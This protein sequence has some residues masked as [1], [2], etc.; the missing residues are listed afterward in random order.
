MD[1]SRST[2]RPWCIALAIACAPLIADAQI[3]SG[4]WTGSGTNWTTTA[5]NVTITASAS[6]PMGPFA[7]DILG[8][9]GAYSTSA[10]DLK[11]SLLI[12]YT[13]FT[14]TGT[15]TFTFS[16][17][18]KDPIL[19]LDRIG[20]NQL[21]LATSGM[22]SIETPAVTWTKLSANGT[23]FTTSGTTVYRATSVLCASGVECGSALSIV[24]GGPASGSL[25]VN[26]TISS[27]TLSCVAAPGIPLGNPGDEFEITWSAVTQAPVAGDDAFALN[28]DGALNT[29]VTGNDSDPDTP[30]AQ[31]VWSLVN[32]GTAAANG[33]LTLNANGTFSYVPAPNFNGTVSFTYRVCDPNGACDDA[34]VTLSVA[35]IN[36]QPVALD[37]LF[38]TAEDVTLNASVGTNDSDV[39]TPAAGLTWSLV[40]GGTAAANG[41][42]TLL[43]NGTFSYAPNT[44]FNGTVSFTYRVC[45][46]SSSCGQAV[47]T[48]IVD[49]VNDPP[50]AGADAFTMPEDG[51]LNGTVAGNDGDVDDP[52][53]DLTWSLVSGGSAAANG[54]LS[55]QPNGAFTY[56]PAPN[57]FGVVSFTYRLCDDGGL[58]VQT[59]AAI[60][61]TPVNDPP[62]AG[63]DGFTMNED[64]VLN[65]SVTANDGDVDD[66]L[67]ALA[68]SLVSGGSAAANG[69][70]VFNPDGS[71]SYTPAVNFSG[72]V[73]F[74]YRLCDAAVACD[75][76]TVT[77]TVTPVNDAPVANDDNATVAEDVVLN[78]SVA[79]NDIDV[80]NPAAQLTWSLLDGGT[81][82]VDGTLLFNADGTFTFTPVLDFTGTVWFTYRLC[83]PGPLCDDATV[84]IVVGS[85]NDPPVAVDD[86]FSLLEDGS[87]SASVAGNDSDPDGDPLVWSLIDGGS[88]AANGVLVFNPDGSFQ[89]TPY[90][91]RNGVVSFTYQACDPSSVCGHATATITIDP[92]NDAPFAGDDAFTMLEDGS[93]SNAV[94]G[95]DG[96]AET[97]SAG[98]V[99]SLVDGGTAAA[100]GVLVFLAD[101]TFTYAPDADVNGTVTFIYALCDPGG[102]CDQAT[103]TITIAPVN[104]APFAG[105][106]AFSLPEDG[107][108]SAAVS[109]NDGD[110]DHSSA[111]LTWSLVDGGTAAAN[112]ALVLHPDGTFTYAPNA[113][114]NGT[115]AFTY[116]V[117]D[118][119]GAC[120]P[121]VVVLSVLPV[122]DPP[123]A[124]DDAFVM[125]EEGVLNTSAAAN[126]GDVD[127]DPLSF[128]LV[129]GG[130][131]AAS[132]S[133]VFA[134]DGTF[135]YAPATDVNGLVSFTYRAC[136]GDGACDDAVVTITITPVN[137]VPLARDDAFSMLEDGILSGDVTPNDEDVDGDVLTWSLID[138]GSAAAN[139]TLT[140]QPDGS[141]IYVPAADL[142]GVVGFR[143]QVCDP[144]GACDPADVLITISPVN[145]GPVAVD[146]GFTMSEDGALSASVATNDSDPDNTLL[147]LTWSLVS[148]GTAA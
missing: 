127:G 90:A 32:G 41:T 1:L 109:G 56:T 119:L 70:L 44:D 139:G 62:V 35:A 21:L 146:D 73:S 37:D 3:V 126:D 91:D 57:F 132:G 82:V 145:D 92:V 4:T 17:P 69:V 81:A 50:H 85:T 64:A 36:D 79:G 115:L 20:G 102:L 34:T 148:G 59:T 48:I 98:L 108:L 131:A 42:L 33:A 137:D 88:A 58:C 130:T 47:A 26:G 63:D 106:D 141:F 111:Q 2:T 23:H 101:G 31:L 86:A 11:P 80:D 43:P 122:N 67:P 100:N 22:L 71:F 104:D 51:T 29:S 83:D 95:N 89:F 13:D 19:H 110:P 144:S 68:W 54:A 77:I 143:Y 9:A 113:N 107:S 30:S 84:T 5:G 118:P 116:Q 12:R 124:V 18:V 24:L 125:D 112:G 61:V 134:P 7:P 138:G 121:A 123:V 53:G 10:V 133:L 75:P 94:S 99:W 60:T 52:N 38:H 6:G 66:A 46:P 76:A 65:A 114:V 39:E 97:V 55:L 74:T 49:P 8:C 72:T 45:D 129:D 96:D 78:G 87:L 117:C 16:T 40:N 25:Q 103:V 93:L 136:D 140:L 105:D 147:Q 135:L 142:N 28:E 15:L 14:Q 120:D 128:I 27:L